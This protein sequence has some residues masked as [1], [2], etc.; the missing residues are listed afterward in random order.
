MVTA[1]IASQLIPHFLFVVAGGINSWWIWSQLLFLDR[2][3]FLFYSWCN[4]KEAIKKKRR[5]QAVTKIL[6]SSSKFSGSYVLTLQTMK[7]DPENGWRGRRLQEERIARSTLRNAWRILSSSELTFH[8]NKD[9][10]F[11]ERWVQE[12]W[13]MKGS[14]RPNHQLNHGRHQNP[15]ITGLFSFIMWAGV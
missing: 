3:C 1:K 7:W 8:G 14:C 5:D 2:F 4:P 15:F 10:E 13:L 12:R 9:E 6:T 11:H